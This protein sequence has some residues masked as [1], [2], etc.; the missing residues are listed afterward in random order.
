MQETYENLKLK[1]CPLFYF[2]L[3]TIYITQ[4]ITQ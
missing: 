1:L 2:V 4:I 3:P